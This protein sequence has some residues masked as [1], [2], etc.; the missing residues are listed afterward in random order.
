MDPS[1]LQALYEF[2]LQLETTKA[3][4]YYRTDDTGNKS[5]VFDA[6]VYVARYA[7]VNAILSLP[8]WSDQIKKVLSPPN[9]MQEIPAI[10]QRH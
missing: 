4:S 3:L 7:C 6:P 1:E 5:I 10:S 9:A 8:Q 2:E